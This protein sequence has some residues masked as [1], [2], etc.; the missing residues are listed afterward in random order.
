MMR[1]AL[2]FLL[3]AAPAAVH[4]Q[5]IRRD[6]AGTMARADSAWSSG[7]RRLARTLYAEA[8][9]ADSTASRAVFRLAQLEDDDARA[10]RLYRR[11]IALEPQDAWG[12]MAEGDILA[13][14]GRVEEALVAYDGARAI[15]PRERD[16]ALGRARVLDQAGRSSQAADELEAWTTMHP[17]DGE[18]WDLLGRSRMRAGRPR[19]ASIAFEH[20]AGLGIRGAGIRLDAAR[21]AAA[22]SIT[23]EGAAS[24]DSDGNQS[25]RFGGIVDFM[26]ADGLRL[27]AGGSYHVVSSDVE[28]V[29]GTNVDARLAATPSSMVRLNGSIGMIR[30]DG[31]A[32]RIGNGVPPRRPAAWSSLQASARIRVRTPATGPSLDVRL[33]RAPLGF[34]PLLIQNRVARSEARATVEIPLAAL[35]LRGIGRFADLDAAGEPSNTRTSLEGALVLPLGA[36]LQPSVQVR[37]TTYRHASA[38]GYFAPQ[39]AETME[40]GLYAESGEDGPLS[41]S[42]DVGGG[43][44]RVTPHGGVVGPWSRVWRAWAQ[45][46]LS[47]GPSRSWFVEAEAYDAPFALEGAGAAGAWRFLSLSSGLRWAIR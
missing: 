4:S 32:G 31:A 6:P 18:A 26:A 29:R 45:A 24:G 35:R 33:E 40:A 14:M 28:D 17:D 38:A 42:A 19:A 9:A 41:L 12:H 46:A 23:P 30:Y 44:Q 37:R 7:D 10:L 22:P 39:L 8:L 16:V 27:G 34:N 21:S 13:R 2:A 1:S 3:L 15:S 47:V 25:T 20:A 43:V 11:Y 5:G 36:G